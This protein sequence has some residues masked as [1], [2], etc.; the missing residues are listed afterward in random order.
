MPSIDSSAAISGLASAAKKDAA[1]ASKSAAE[2][3]ADKMSEQFLTLL[4]AQMKN[5]TPTKPMDNSQLTSQIA[6]INTVSGI[7][8]LNTTLAKING[9][10][11]TSQQL[12]ASALIDHRVLVK[13][14]E[15]GVGAKG[16]ATPFGLDLASSAQ[17]VALTITDDAGTVVHRSTYKDQPAGTQSFSWD[18]K[19]AAG[20]RVGA[21]SYHVAIEATDA[22]G[23]TVSATPLMMGL[24][25]GVVAGDAGPQLDLG[26]KGLV[27][28]ADV[29]Q[30][31]GSS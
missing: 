24:V 26:P 9:Q 15:I 19:D 16:D 25:N 20:K 22:D 3:R 13:G 30:I 31:V 1:N 10:I 7:N 4:V 18:G 29:R 2:K 8:D 11:D 12:Q 21:G 5:Q 6:Q 14:N 23:A 28:L 17:N 27:A